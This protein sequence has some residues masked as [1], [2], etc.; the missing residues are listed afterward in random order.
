MAEYEEPSN[1]QKLIGSCEWTKVYFD[2][3]LVNAG[4]PLIVIDTQDL[5]YVM[6]KCLGHSFEG[7]V[8]KVRRLAEDN[9]IR[10]KPTQL[11]ILQAFFD[12]TTHDDLYMLVRNSWSTQ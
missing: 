1:S 9:I 5:K 2:E 10:L 3:D 7:E 8:W 11:K 4:Q 6:E 12:G